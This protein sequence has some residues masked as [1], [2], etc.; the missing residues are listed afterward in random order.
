MGDM[1]EKT[2]IRISVWLDLLLVYGVGVGVGF[3]VFWTDSTSAG[4]G[5]SYDW[6]PR[7]LIAACFVGAI[8]LVGL[9]LR[10]SFIPTAFVALLGVLTNFVVFFVWALLAG[11]IDGCTVNCT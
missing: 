6:P 3:W 7:I 1:E 9:L 11:G 4:A 5:D 2:K 10:R 8:G